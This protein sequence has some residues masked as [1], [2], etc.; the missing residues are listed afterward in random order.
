M[1]LT[2]FYLMLGTNLPLYQEKMLQYAFC[3]YGYFECFKIFMMIF[4]KKKNV[5]EYD[6]Y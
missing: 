4:D 2:G 1:T 6:D 3:K 5:W